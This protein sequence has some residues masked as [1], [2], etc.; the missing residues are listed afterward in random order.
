MSLTAFV[1][2]RELAILIDN[3]EHMLEACGRLARAVLEH[4][5]GVRLLVTSREPLGIDGEWVWRVPSLPTPEADATA[6]GVLR[7]DAG[8]LFDE[9]ARQAR[10]DFRVT[11]DNATSVARI[12][13]RLDGIPL[14][15]ELA[16]A[17]ARIMTPE[18]IA[19]GLDDRFRLLTGGPRR[20]VPRQQTLQS[21]VEWSHALLDADEQRAFRRLAVFSGGFTLAAAEAV[22]VDDAL[23]REAVLDLLTRL[24]DKSLATS[25]ETGDQ[26]RHRLLETI[27]QYAHDRL[28]ESGELSALRDRHLAWCVELAATAEPELT[29]SHQ[30]PALHMLEREHDNLRAAFDWAYASKAG[31]SLWSLAGNLA[32]FWVLHGHFAEASQ[33]IERAAAVGDDVPMNEQLAGR[34]ASVVHDVLLGSFRACR[35]RSARRARAGAPVSRRPDPHPGALHARGGRDVLRRPHRPRPPPGGRCPG[36]RAR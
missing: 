7:S 1:G 31:S 17:R 32:H 3:A 4:A 35:A 30:L 9:R 8:R 36:H 22:I 15:I 14:A 10:A 23:A 34:W 2:D 11:D 28:S 20:S 33:T 18:R 19:A 21:S 29:S 16:A 12:C 27:R 24:V 26:L 5:P 13:R 25:E 6:A